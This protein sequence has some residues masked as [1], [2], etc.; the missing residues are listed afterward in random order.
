MNKN[1]PEGHCP[2]TLKRPKAA[3]PA[4]L[5][6]DSAPWRLVD[7]SGSMLRDSDGYSLRFESDGEALKW[8][9][10]HKVPLLPPRMK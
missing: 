8:L 10:A 9:K 3:Y 6:L 4:Y 2:I 1:L 7:K 5:P